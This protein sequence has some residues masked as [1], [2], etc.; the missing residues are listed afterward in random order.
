M[1]ELNAIFDAIKSM[2]YIKIIPLL[3]SGGITV[4]LI[5]QLSKILSAIKNIILQ[6]IS[7]T[8]VNIHEDARA[9]GGCLYT[10]KQMIFNEVISNC[11]TLWERTNNLDLE[12]KQHG[13]KFAPVYHH[14]NDDTTSRTQDINTYGFSIKILYGKLIICNRYIT[15]EGQKVM[16]NT[17]LRIF[18]GSRLKFLKK[19]EEDIYNKA[20]ERENEFKNS[21]IVRIEY[22][23]NSFIKE[24]RKLDSVFTKDN[25]HLNLYNDILN[26]LNNKDTYTDLNHPYHYSALLYGKPGTG[27]TSTIL[28]IASKLNK[29]ICYVNISR[30]KAEDFMYEFSIDAKDYIYVFEDIDA[31]ST[32]FNSNRLDNKDDNNTIKIKDSD[33]ISL[34]ELLNI[35]DGLLSC[36]GTICI[37]TTNHIE[38]LDSAL[39]RAGRMNKL[40]EFDYMDPETANRMIQTHLNTK[41]DNLKDEIKPAELQDMLL[42][43]KLGTCNIEQLK[44]KFCK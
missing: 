30:T 21:S 28:A 31:C 27:K 10:Y 22:N 44:E 11:T 12:R 38:K 32:D 40:V 18:F 34:S 26:F 39:L 2:D 24:K 23:G 9:S 37:F 43:I 29:R 5:G 41:I 15:S 8:I 42:N 16:I 4:W 20:V 14:N 1:N 35:T 36:D 19:L 25:I 6:L 3:A 17:H 7:F 13:K 33:T